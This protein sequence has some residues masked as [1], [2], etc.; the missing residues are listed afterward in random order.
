MKRLVTAA[1]AL[2]AVSVIAGS[3]LAANG[4]K[5]TV[6]YDTTSPNGPPTNLVSY[7]PAAYGFT[8]I[9]DKITLGGTARNLTAATVTLSSWACQTGTWN[10]NNCATQAGA[11]F[12]QPITLT[13]KDAAT[14]NQLA[15]STQTFDVPYRPSASPKCTGADAGKWMSPKDGCKNGL[16]NEVAFTNFSPSNVT[17]PD[18]VVYEI[19]YPTGGPA[20]SLN[21]AVTD[22]APSPG[23]T[24]DGVWVDGAAAPGFD[25]GWALANHVTPAVQ[26]KASNKS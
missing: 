2:A 14:G 5:P 21:V 1:L 15:T 11:T 26:L 17:L 19:S 13:I 16:A 3:A 22:Q 25:G 7:G 10:G 12:Q 6:I 9:G 20:D 8:T 18:A 4:N 24:E 23:A